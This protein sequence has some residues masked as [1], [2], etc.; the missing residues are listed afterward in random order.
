VD[1][2]AIVTMIDVCAAFAVCV[3]RIVID[4]S[5][6]HVVFGLTVSVEVALQV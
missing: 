6:S 4:V 1:V 2:S 5:D 3:A